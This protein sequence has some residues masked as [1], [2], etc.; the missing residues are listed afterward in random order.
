MTD[1]E[2]SSGEFPFFFG[3]EDPEEKLVEFFSNPEGWDVFNHRRQVDFHLAPDQFL[4]LGDNSAESKDSRLWEADSPQYYISR[5]LLIGRALF[6]YW[7]HS[8]G[9][10]PGTDGWPGL[11]NGI[12]F[13]FFPNFARMG[14]VR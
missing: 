9:R 3:S 5:D 13:P 14:F 2:T 10:V 11:P 8:W 12:W 4:A 6:I 1:Y 7:P